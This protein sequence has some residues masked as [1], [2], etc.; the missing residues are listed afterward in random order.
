MYCDVQKD[1]A[2]CGQ[3]WLKETL[4]VGQ[5]ALL[6]LAKA[7][8]THCNAHSKISGPMGKERYRHFILI[9]KKKN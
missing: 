9:L 6:N 8:E 7:K 3:I 4:M 1:E 2:L 5:S